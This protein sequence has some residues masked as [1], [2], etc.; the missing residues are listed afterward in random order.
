[1]EYVDKLTAYGKQVFTTDQLVK[2]FGSWNDA[3]K[4]ALFRLKR[5]GIIASPAKGF[6]VILTPQ[7]REWGCLPPDKFIPQLMS[8]WGIDY[9]VCLLSAA[10]YQGAAHQK[11]QMFQVM[12]EKNRRMIQCGKMRIQ[13]LANKNLKFTPTE[14][15]QT[16]SGYLKV[17]TPE[18]TAKDLLSYPRQSGG[19]N[20]IAT[21]L[22]ELGEVINPESLMKL[23]VESLE[24]QWVQRLGYLLELL[25][26]TNL[27]EELEKYLLTQKINM[28]PL[29]PLIKVKDCPRNEKWRLIINFNVESDI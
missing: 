15:K 21:V 22:S 18:A 28:I 9:Y 20:H 17:S 8:Y 14:L 4:K 24:K 3:L 27:S 5:K 11:P 19:L 6:Y 26:H 16:E 7:Y 13:F 10:M 23:S 1:M 29:T 2:D 12:V 25:G